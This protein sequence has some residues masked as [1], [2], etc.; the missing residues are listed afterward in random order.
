MANSQ[1][2]PSAFKRM[3][4]ASCRV[5]VNRE[6]GNLYWVGS[7]LGELRYL[8][9]VGLQPVNSSGW[10]LPTLEAPPEPRQPQRQGWSRAC[11]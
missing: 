11:T 7:L 9:M 4:R 2:L 1:Q 8:M 5:S 10:A 3:R 6:P